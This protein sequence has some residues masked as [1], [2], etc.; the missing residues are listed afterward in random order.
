M[1]FDELRARTEQAEKLTSSGDDRSAARAL[2]ELAQSDLPALDRAMAWTHAASAHERLGD[3]DAA[4]AD[5]DRA[6]ALETPLLRFAAA[7][8]K[9]D[10]LLRLGR[11][12]ESRDLFQSLLTRPEA[13]LAERHSF[14]SRLKLL[15]RVPGKT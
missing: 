5:Y 6:V 3:A 14:E 8:K 11:K 9:A 4:L 1:D 2:S 10:Y 13:T 12:D 7:F 15:R